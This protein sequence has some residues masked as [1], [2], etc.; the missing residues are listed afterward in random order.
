MT[1]GHAGRNDTPPT[2]RTHNTCSGRSARLAE[3]SNATIGRVAQHGPDSRALPPSAGFARRDA[4]GVEPSGNLA[5][6]E[7]IHR[8]HLIDA[9]DHAS[10]GFKHNVCGRRHVGLADIAV[11][12]R[13]PTHHADFTGLSP[14]SFAAARPL[15]DLRSFVLRD[16]P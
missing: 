4:F 16:H 12:I 15:Q 7:A 8:V 3:T 10:L 1:C 2:L 9:L 11:A 13:S 5:D 6:A 14:V